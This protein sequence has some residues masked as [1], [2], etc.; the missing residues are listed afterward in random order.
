MIGTGKKGYSRLIPFKGAAPKEQIDT[1]I[2]HYGGK[3]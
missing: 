1:S 2:G 3:E